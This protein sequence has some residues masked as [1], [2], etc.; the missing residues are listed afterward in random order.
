M[1]PPPPIGNDHAENKASS[2]FWTAKFGADESQ[3][4][5]C[6]V[7]RPNSLSAFPGLTGC[8][9]ECQSRLA[10]EI[11]LPTLEKNPANGA[12]PMIGGLPAPPP[13]ENAMVKESREAY[14]ERYLKRVRNPVP[15]RGRVG[16][17]TQEAGRQC[18]NWDDDQQTVILLLN[19][20]LTTYGGTDLTLR[21]VIPGHDRV[22]LGL[23]KRRT[24]IKPSCISRKRIFQ[25][26]VRV[27]L[28]PAG[29][30]SGALGILCLDPP[31]LPGPSRRERP[32]V[33][34][35][36][37]ERSSRLAL[38]WRRHYFPGSGTCALP[39]R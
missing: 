30:C 32:R 18:Q 25:T 2:G 14:L 29:Q 10:S 39:D 15:L 6:A 34:T 28:N 33:A 21:G 20:T 12:D 1:P 5:H 36:Y 7:P 17:H 26:R 8:P 16:R 27:F 19:S 38:T 37:L 22:V 11:S 3:L 13:G 9:V 23:C 35:P 24:C 31:G 4:V